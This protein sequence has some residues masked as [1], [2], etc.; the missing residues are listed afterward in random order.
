MQLCSEGILSQ[1]KMLPIHG[2]ESLSLPFAEHDV[3]LKLPQE[4]Q[5]D[6]LSLEVAFAPYKNAGPFIFPEGMIPVS[7]IVWFCLQPQKEFVEPA[8]IKLPHC[9]DC[10]TQEDAK[11]LFFLKA[12]HGNIKFNKDGQTVIEFKY[13]DQA[14]SD[15]QPGSQYGTLKD[16]HFCIYCIAYSSLKDDIL[17]NV[18]YRLTIQRP[19]AYPRDEK[20][21]IY[22][23][24][25][26]DLKGCRQVCTYIHTFSACITYHTPTSYMQLVKE[27]MP[28]DYEFTER[29]MRFEN[30]QEALEITVDKEDANEKGWMVALVSKKVHT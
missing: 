10:K 24:L 1:R 25:Y 27:Q 5:H 29:A 26:Y 4:V 15:F 9:F 12:E 16:Y 30:Q 3:Y 18:Q 17:K 13:V 19:M 11:S 23:I 21:D 20:K 14:L 6:N 8:T 22:C 2:F 7:P 28:L